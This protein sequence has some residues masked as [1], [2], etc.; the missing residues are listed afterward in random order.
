LWRRRAEPAC[1]A[2]LVGWITAA[3]GMLFDVHLGEPGGLLLPVLLAGATWAMAPAER[4]PQLSIPAW[5]PATPALA[6]LVCALSE[7]FGDGGSAVSIHHRARARMEQQDN[8]GRLEELERMRRRIGPLD[9]IDY[10]RALVLGRLGRQEESTAALIIQLRKLPCDCGA[11]ALAAK[12]RHA[13]RATP[14]LIAAEATARSEAARWL[15]AVPH[16]GSN[17]LRIEGLRQVL[18]ADGPDQAR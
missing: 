3:C 14:E 18:A 9:T 16:T 8:A 10:G 17:A 13:G 5:L 11:L 12:V 7:L 1:A 15:G 2:L 4:A 6:M